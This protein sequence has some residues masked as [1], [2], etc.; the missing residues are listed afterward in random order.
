MDVSRGELNLPWISVSGGTAQVGTVNEPATETV[1]EPAPEATGE[2]PFHGCG[3]GLEDVKTAVI[4][5]RLGTFRD[6][7]SAPSQHD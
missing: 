3:A 4:Q 2:T 6:Q 1:S 5:I 7:K